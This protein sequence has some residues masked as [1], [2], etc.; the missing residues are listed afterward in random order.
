[1]PGAPSNC[2]QSR[3]VGRTRIGLRSLVP[4]DLALP[5]AERRERASPGD[6]FDAAPVAWEIVRH[7]DYRDRHLWSFGKYKNYVGRTTQNVP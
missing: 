2:A 4:D 5:L 6:C 7:E 1:M 3:R